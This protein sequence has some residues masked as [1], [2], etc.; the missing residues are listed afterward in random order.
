M[1]HPLQLDHAPL[2]R[3]LLKPLGAALAAALALPVLGAF[4]RPLCVSLQPEIPWIEPVA[5]SHGFGALMLALAFWLTGISPLAGLRRAAAS[6]RGRSALDA[7]GGRWFLV[8]GLVPLLITLIGF[9]KAMSI[10]LPLSTRPLYWLATGLI[11]GLAEEY[12][13]RGPLF[14]LL[15]GFGPRAAIYGTAA[16]FALLHLGNFRGAPDALVVTA[17]IFGALVTGLCWGFM[18]WRWRTVWPGAAIHGVG[19]FVAFLLADGLAPVVVLDPSPH[20]H[21]M[22]IALGL[23]MPLLAVGL[24]WLLRQ[25]GRARM[26]GA[27]VAG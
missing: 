21:Q 20:V 25:P 4:I 16:V 8:F 26:A 15:A 23:A 12:A 22:R 5:L 3:R 17:Q 11:V 18:R 10:G 1:P 7:W 13:V 19:D 14:E 9:S 24:A 27:P 2:I 6:R